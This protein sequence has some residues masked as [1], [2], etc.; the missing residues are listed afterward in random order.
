[1][2]PN[3]RM[4]LLYLQYAFIFL[5][6]LYCT[7]YFATQ[8]PQGNTSFIT[9]PVSPD[10]TKNISY[11]MVPDRYQSQPV[12]NASVWLSRLFLLGS[13]SNSPQLIT[14]KNIMSSSFSQSFKFHDIRVGGNKKSQ[15]YCPKENNSAC[16][17][18]ILP[19]KKK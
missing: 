11:S 6:L 16:T 18:T 15:T 19:L 14:I 8:V 10:D 1:M 17:G 2:K 3:L 13:P 9:L 4:N 12:C 7:G 5:L